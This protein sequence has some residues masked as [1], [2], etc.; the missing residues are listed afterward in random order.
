MQI[1][2]TAQ[3]GS[4][5]FGLGAGKGGGIGAP[6]GAGTCLGTN[7]GSGVGG[8]ISDAFYGRYLSSALQER[9]QR[10]SKVNRLVFTA[11]FA[12]WISPSGKVTKIELVRSSGDE[13]RDAILENILQGV[14]GLDTPPSSYRFPQRITVRGRRSL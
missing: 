4:D 3:A 5:S 8:G 7:C 13:K 12:I 14:S 1:D 10:D 9:V 6:G 2:S 11:D